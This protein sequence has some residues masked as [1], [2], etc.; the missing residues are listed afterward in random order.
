[1]QVHIIQ[2]ENRARGEKRILV[3]GKP[4]GTIKMHQHGSHGASY[5]FHQIGIYGEITEA[6]P[7]GRSVVCWSRDKYAG[8][9]SLYRGSKAPDPIPPLAERLLATAQ[10]LVEMTLLRDPDLVQAEHAKISAAR[11]EQEQRE[12]DRNRGQR[13]A[14]AIAM[15]EKHIPTATREQTHALADAIIGHYWG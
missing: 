3:D 4:W 2:P 14:R 8:R 7:R 13:M 10:R 6:G 1:M 11:K 5:S 9:D 15:I 12:A